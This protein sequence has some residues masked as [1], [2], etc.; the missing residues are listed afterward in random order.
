MGELKTIQQK[1][2]DLPKSEMNAL[3]HW[4]D[5]VV[6]SD[7]IANPINIKEQKFDSEAWDR[8]IEADAKSGKLDFLKAEALEAKE[9]GL[10][11]EI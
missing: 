10:L 4:L 2:M 9:K 8:Q 5:D 6:G 11:K 3:K 1:I 7:P